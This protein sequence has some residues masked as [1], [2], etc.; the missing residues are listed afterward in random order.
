MPESFYDRVRLPLR[1][2]Q[3]TAVGR[4]EHQM[5]P[6]DDVFDEEAT[7]RTYQSLIVGMPPLNRQLLLYLMDFLA[8][9]ASK[10]ELNK[11]T[12]PKLAAIFQPGLLSNSQDS[13]SLAERQLSQDVLVF[14]IENQ[15]H[16]L[17]GMPGTAAN[18]DAVQGVTGA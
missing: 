2:H 12:T 11:M 14:L 5:S 17:I 6:S 7:I 16:F 18:N 8:V 15:D 9:F 4:V 3:A 13:S 10:S 1:G